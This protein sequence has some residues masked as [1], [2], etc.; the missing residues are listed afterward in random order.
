MIIGA[1]P[2]DGPGGRCY[3]VV[4]VQGVAHSGLPLPSGTTR[5]RSAERDRD[6]RGR[7]PRTS[8]TQPKPRQRAVGARGRR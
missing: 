5:M 6:E 8:P 1:G 4:R 2:V 7:P 3:S